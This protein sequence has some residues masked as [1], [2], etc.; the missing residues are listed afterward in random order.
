MVFGELTDTGRALIA[1]VFPEHT[2]QIRQGMRGLSRQ[3]KRQAAELLMKLGIGAQ[4][5]IE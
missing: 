3:E 5:E 4:A 1:K 2:E